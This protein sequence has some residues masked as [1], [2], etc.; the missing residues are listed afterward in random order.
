[1]TRKQFNRESKEFYDKHGNDAW[2]KSRYHTNVT[3]ETHN[4]TIAHYPR[5]SF[6][7]MYYVQYLK[8]LGQF[9]SFAHIA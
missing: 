2:L 9:K 7:D 3:K 5:L 4:E 8:D 6:S 1:M